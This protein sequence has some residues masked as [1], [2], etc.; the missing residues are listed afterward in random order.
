MSADTDVTIHDLRRNLG[1][2]M[3]SENVNMAL[4]KGALNHKDMETTLNV[5]AKTAKQSER[6]AQLI[7]HAAAAGAA[8]LDL[9]KGVDT[10]LDNARAAMCGLCNVAVWNTICTF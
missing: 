7:G 3:A 4:V 1:S 6:E 5:Y 9:L 8:G 10:E 2:W